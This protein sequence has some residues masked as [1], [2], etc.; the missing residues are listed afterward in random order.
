MGGTGPAFA[1][2]SAAP[3]AAG[4]GRG[5]ER[6]DFDGGCRG[7]PVPALPR[8][9][10]VQRAGS[11]RPRPPAAGQRPRDRAPL[12]ARVGLW[13]RGAARPQRLG[14]AGGQADT[15]FRARRRRLPGQLAGLH[16]LRGQP[17]RRPRHR[18]HPAAGRHPDL[19]QRWQDDA[20]RRAS[21][22]RS[23]LLRAAL[24]H[25]PLAA[26]RQRRHRGC[27]LL[28]R[29]GHRPHGHGPCGL[30]R[31]ARAPHSPRRFHDHPAAGQA[32]PAGQL[33]DLRTQAQGGVP[34]HPGRAL[35]FQAP[36]PG[37]VP[38]HGPLR[39]QL[40][41]NPGGLAHL[42]PQG[43]QGP[44]PGAGRDAGGH[45]PE[46]A[47]QQPLQQLGPGQGSPAVG[48][49][50]DGARPHDRPA[51]RRPGLRGGPESPQREDVR[52]RPPG[53]GSD[54]LRVLGDGPDLRQVRREGPAG[55]WPAGGDDAQHDAPGH[56]REGHDQPAQRPALAPRQPG[57]PHRHR[58]PHRRGGGDGG[59]R[60]SRRPRQQQQL[61]G[62]AAAQPR[63]VVQDLQLHGGDRQREVH[64]GYAHRRQPDHDHQPEP[65]LAAQE[66]R[67]EVPR[68]LPAAAVHGQLAERAGG[69]GRARQRRRQGRA[70]RA[71]HG[72]AALDPAAQRQVHQR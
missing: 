43:D 72:S 9:P 42:L 13:H 40:A 8:F 23:A 25:G 7:A 68:D 26:G 6:L 11:G 71:R 5:P 16:R 57:R 17:A 63:I 2:R 21:G 58:S 27:Q 60:R 38:E 36:D 15:R 18:R 55:R 14:A 31:L 10:P 29:A 51:T 33:T 34:G 69:Q 53:A 59:R 37:D 65:A 44:R 32:A 39:E 24:Q 46:P 4:R 52:A 30:G 47:L 35:L 41:G 45:S 12:H 70:D 50:R 62:L 22:G 48:P 56:R 67:H 20:G 61:R 3:P 54:R 49:G 19:C 64:D 66:L 1:G 28:A